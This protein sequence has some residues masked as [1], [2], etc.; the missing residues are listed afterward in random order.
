MFFVNSLDNTLTIC[1]AFIE[2]YFNK[3]YLNHILL[4]IM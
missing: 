2:Y 3:L 1:Y 4:K